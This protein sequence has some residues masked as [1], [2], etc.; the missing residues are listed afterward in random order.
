MKRGELMN[1]TRVLADELT[2]APEGLFTNVELRTLIN[3]S[4][5]NVQADLMIYMPWYF[6]AIKKISLTINKR[7]Y[8]IESIGTLHRARTTNVATVGTLITHGLAIDDSITISNMSGTGYNGTYTV[9]SV[10][11]GA[12][13]TY[14][15]TGADEAET[16]DTGGLIETG[17]SISDLLMIEK[18]VPINE[19][20]GKSP[21][22]YLEPKNIWLHGGQGLTG[23]P[24]AW[25]YESRG[26]IFFEPTPSATISDAVKIYYIKRVPDLNDDEIDNPPTKIAT[27]SLPEEAH[28]L[29]ALDVLRQ[30]FIRERSQSTDVNERYTNALQ[31]IVYQLSS[32]GEVKSAELPKRTEAEKAK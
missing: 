10:I 14:T 11:D 18:I 23:I 6:R 21:F 22:L 19:S 12:H 26:Q 4:Q 7:E 28:Q 9:A 31:A 13:F 8:S 27:S 17:S 16:V 32:P 20:L 25:G 29:I 24:R 1:L 3:V 5:K 30:W 15:N 2:E